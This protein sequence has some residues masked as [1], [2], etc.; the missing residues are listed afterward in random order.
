MK[1]FLR[2]LVSPFLQI[3]APGYSCCKRCF[4]PWKFTQHHDTR[5]SPSR[6]CFPLCESCWATLKPVTRL[7]YYRVM[8]RSWREADPS[9]PIEWQE[10][11][12]AVL[13]GR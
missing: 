5:Y 9:G 7:L 10:I 1:L 4:I 13:R 3:V 8:Y 11:E 2:R 6:S 12:L